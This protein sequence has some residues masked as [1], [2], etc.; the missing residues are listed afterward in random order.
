M[1]ISF[2]VPKGGEVCL[3]LS[4]SKRNSFTVYKNGESL[5]TET[6][7]LDQMLSLGK[8]NSGDEIEVAFR[9]K[10]N[11]TGRLEITAAVLDESVFQEGVHFL[12]QSPMEIQSMT[13][14]SLTGT[15]EVPESSLL[16]TSIPSNGNWHVTVDGVEAEPVIICGV[17]MGLR[18][19]PGWHTI[20]FSYHNPALQQGIVV[21]LASL[22]G[23]LGLTALAYLPRRRGK[24]QNP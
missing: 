18:L 23:F 2:T 15:V 13:D 1:S 5:L 20:T 8:C 4:A 22:A 9:C 17:M 11:E 6:M 7:S 14:T 21:S 12:Q 16:Y 24:F 10:A 19:T 3:D